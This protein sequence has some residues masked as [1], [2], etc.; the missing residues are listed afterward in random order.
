LVS[1]PPMLFL[2]RLA[3][4]RQLLFQR[5]F[6]LSVSAGLEGRQLPHPCSV[7][8]DPVLSF[9]SKRFSFP[10]EI[11]NLFGISPPFLALPEVAFFPPEVSLFW[12]HFVCFPTNSCG[13]EIL[14]LTP[15]VSLDKEGSSLPLFHSRNP[16]RLICSSV[17][18][19]PCI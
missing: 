3:A 4:S 5:N 8:S 14:V 2:V 6:L 19:S 1:S 13:S 7:F 16:I 18:R 12:S 9:C 10:L 15:C 17:F 11:Y